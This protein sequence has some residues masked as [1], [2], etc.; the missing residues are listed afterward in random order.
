MAR[1]YHAGMLD[2]RVT[3]QRR[4]PAT[5]ALGERADVWTD[6]VTVFAR[7]EPL[8][9]RAQFAAGQAQRATTHVVVMRYRADLFGAGE[10]RLVHHARGGA[11]EPMEIDGEP[12]DVDSAGQWLEINA[13]KGVRDGR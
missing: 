8:R 1:T 2:R 10:W 3:V 7:V 11:L 13:I 4:D 5:N 9:S 12:I 6:V